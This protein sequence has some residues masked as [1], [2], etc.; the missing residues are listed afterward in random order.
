[1]DEE[2]GEDEANNILGQKLTHLGTAHHL[3]LL[4]HMM[5]LLRLLSLLK[6]LELL[7]SLLVEIELR[8]SVGIII[9]VNVPIN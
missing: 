4:H 1:M 9:P 3:V 2:E 6:L 5:K 7:L 8:W